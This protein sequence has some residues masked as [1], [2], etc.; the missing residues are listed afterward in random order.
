MGFSN[1]EVLVKFVGNTEGLDKKTK[2]A[3]QTIKGFGKSVGGVLGSIGT[4]AL[5]TSALITVE[6][7]KGIGKIVQASVEAYSQF[8]QLEGGLVS[9]FGEGSAEMNRILEDSRNAYKSLTMSQNDYLTNFQSAYPLVNAGLNNNKDAIE[10]TNKMLQLS[11]DLFNT[12]GGSIDYYQNAINWALKGS[13]VY[14]D[15]LNLGIKGTQEGFIEAANNA[16]ILGRQIQSVSELSS[17]EIIDVI[18][19]YA[20]AYGVWGKT[21][22]EASDTIIGSMNMVKAT[23][24][25]LVLGFSQK[26]ADIDGLMDNLVNSAITFLNNVLPVVE[27]ALTSIAKA[28]PM[29]VQKIGDLLPGLLE[30]LLPPLIDACLKLIQSLAKNLPKIIRILGDAII[31]AA[32]GLLDL[33]PDL[34]DAI[35]GG[36]V[37]LIEVLADS[38]PTLLPKLIEA[39][40]DGVVKIVDYVPEVIQAAIDLLMG[41]VKALPTIITALT[42]ALPDLITTI[43]NV[44]IEAIP[45]L[46]EGAIQLLMAIIEA[47]PTIIVILGE[48]LP[49]IIIAIFNALTSNES[50]QKLDQAGKSLLNKIVDGINSLFGK[51]GQV[52]INL[53]LGLWNGIGSKVNWIIGKIRGFGSSVMSAIKGIFGVHSPSTEF[54]WVGKMNILGLEKG[55]EEMQPEL[56]KTINGVFDL[57]PNISGQMSSTYSP[58]TNVIVNNN[59]EI[60]PLGQVVNKIKTFSGGAKNDYNWG[61]TI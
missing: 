37:A 4:L 41:I 42:D 18:Q 35:M 20:E 28:L 24:D 10:Y 58:Q 49:E 55:M 51:I 15:N 39:I 2:E 1:A 53:V 26:D 21:A 44:L 23:W 45:V 33:L 6:A 9:L 30:K 19:Y 13:F 8:E 47:I 38:L 56:Q 12:Y 7:L 34:I 27:R 36:A 11:S 40:I 17:D 32:V 60:D 61:A 29:V 52:G 16:G 22:A 57:Q 48:K 25:N 46:L 59:M 31:Q 43:V 3:S 50:L 54:E 14:L 5:A